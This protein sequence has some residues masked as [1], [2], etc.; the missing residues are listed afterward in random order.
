LPGIER[1][2]AEL[3]KQSGEPGFW[4]NPQAAQATM[5]HLGE[6]RARV[7]A[8]Q[9]IGRQAD[10]LM[11]LAELAEDDPALASEIAA[12]TESLASRLDDLELQSVLNGPHDAA[13]AIMVIH[14]GEGGVDAQDWAEM[15]TRMY[16]RWG[17]RRGFEAEL[18]DLA[19]P[20]GPAPEPAEVD[21]ELREL[22]AADPYTHAAV[23]TEVAAR[24]WQPILPAG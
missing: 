9:E 21:A 3:D 5:R 16:L 7:G 4:D 10:D 24:E 11:G 1:E 19:G 8:W 14:S 20:P 15:L 23:V 22:I 2:I 6:L 17:D 13:N 12:E 18:L